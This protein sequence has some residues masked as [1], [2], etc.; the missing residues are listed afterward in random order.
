MAKM[1]STISH[2]Q[3]L[4]ATLLPTVENRLVIPSLPPKCAS[5]VASGQ[6]KIASRT[7]LTFWILR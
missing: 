5:F 1:S 2:I 3:M 6:A 4:T 7:Y